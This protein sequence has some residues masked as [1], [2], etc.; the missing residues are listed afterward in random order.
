MSKLLSFEHKSPLAN[1][2]WSSSV[3]LE[4]GDKINSVLEDSD[5]PIRFSIKKLFNDELIYTLDMY[6]N[7]W[8][9]H[10]AVEYCYMELETANGVSLFRED[11]DPIKHGCLSDAMFYTWCLKNPGSKGIAIGSNDGAGG[12]YVVP[13]LRGLVGGMVLVEASE[14][15]YKSLER[16]YSED[17]TV[18]TINTLVSTKSEKIKFYESTEGAGLVNSVYPE[19]ANLFNENIIEVEKDAIGINEIILQNS[20]DID[21][22]HIDVEGL[23]AEL[24]MAIDFS[25]IKPKVI[26]YE[27]NNGKTEKIPSSVL[28]D[29]LKSNN[30]EVF[31]SDPQLNN[32]AILKK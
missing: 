9:S 4:I 22:L 14:R 10:P 8:S 1:S 7:Y 5:F 23:D 31:N 6:G 21:W 11:W 32:I 20:E 19:F 12:D 26:I 17:K 29:F 16:N 2:S 27:N 28:I 24:I 13:Y 15:T 3:R 18:K 30:Y 25:I